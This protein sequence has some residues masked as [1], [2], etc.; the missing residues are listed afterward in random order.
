MAAKG[1]KFIF[2]FF[3]RQGE[4]REKNLRDFGFKTM[5]T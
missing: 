1:L 3:I 4:T 2:A 5:C